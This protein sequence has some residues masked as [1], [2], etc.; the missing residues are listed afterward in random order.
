MSIRDIIEAA[1]QN[2]TDVLGEPFFIGSKDLC[3]GFDEVDWRRQE[4]FISTFDPE[5]VALMEAV[6]EEA[7]ANCDG[8]C[9]TDGTEAVCMSCVSYP[10]L[11][12]LDKLDAYRAE[13]GL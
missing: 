13:R 2:A 6:R 12:A 3:Y 4:K 1:K 7:R 5:H 11:C 8:N 10:L 9:H